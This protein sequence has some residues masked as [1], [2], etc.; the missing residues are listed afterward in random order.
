MFSPENE[1]ELKAYEHLKAD[2]TLTAEKKSEIIEA[3]DRRHMRER[4]AYYA[5]MDR[6]H[7]GS[8]EPL[9]EPQR[10][11]FSQLSHTL[12]SLRAGQ[13]KL[14]NTLNEHVSYSKKKKGT[15]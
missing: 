13:N 9:V 12:D 14:E 3:W 10:A 1:A 4:Y 6:E 7:Y 11:E 15:Y 5:R 2:P 8:P